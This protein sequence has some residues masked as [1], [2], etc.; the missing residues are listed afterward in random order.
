MFTNYIS[1][2]ELHLIKHVRNIWIE[3]AQGIFKFQCQGSKNP[4]R[5]WEIDKIRY[6]T[7][8]DV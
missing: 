7:D 6:F 1:D 5:K 3:N 4:T 8:K 2:K